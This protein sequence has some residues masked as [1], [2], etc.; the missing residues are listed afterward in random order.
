[1]VAGKK[2]LFVTRRKITP[3][4]GDFK[5]DTAEFLPPVPGVPF[6]V[7]GFFIF[8]VHSVLWLFNTRNTSGMV[9]G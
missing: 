2:L 7:G 5:N 8:C 6:G 4:P 9:S 1:M 3:S